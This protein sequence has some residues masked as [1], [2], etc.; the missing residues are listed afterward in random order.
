MPGRSRRGTRSWWWH[1]GP[2]SRGLPDW[3]VG[4]CPPA[5]RVGGRSRLLPMSRVALVT[6]SSRGIGRAIAVALAQRGERVAVNFNADADAA[7]ETLSLVEAAGG[8]GVCVQADV[9]NSSEV[10]RCFDEVEEAI[11]PIEILV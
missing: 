7:K 3:F 1:S 8:E 10:K 6:G 11:G 2:G 5:Q 4:V 9:S